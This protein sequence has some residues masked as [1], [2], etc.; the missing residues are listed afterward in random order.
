MS[1]AE[2][3]PVTL[4]ALH[5]DGE[6]SMAL[7]DSR[8]LARIGAVPLPDGELRSLA[9]A[10]W[11]A[12][13]ERTDSAPIARADLFKRLFPASVRSFLEQ[14]PPRHLHLQLAEEL[15]GIPWEQAFDGQNLLGEKF[16]VAR[17]ILSGN[18]IPEP[19]RLRLRGTELKSRGR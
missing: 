6:L 11:A 4:S 17:Q 9:G 13:L 5:L 19:R 14:S 16:A 7:T 15:I 3:R 12:E 18:E 8:G 2:V 10:L 1:L